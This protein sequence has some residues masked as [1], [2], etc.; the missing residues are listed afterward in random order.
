MAATFARTSAPERKMPSRT[1]GWRER[2]SM[3]AN[4]TSSATAATKPPMV[5]AAV[6]PADDV[7]GAQAAAHAAVSRD[8]PRAGDQQRQRDRGREQE[9]EAPALLGQRA[10]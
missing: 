1:S 9:R 4:S 7:E 6:H 3:I 5:L 8:E 2:R 10:A